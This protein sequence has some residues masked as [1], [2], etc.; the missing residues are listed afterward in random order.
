MSTIA[1]S[2]GSCRKVV[3]AICGIS[4]EADEGGKVTCR[5]C[6][7][8]QEIMSKR[9]AAH[10]SL[11]TQGVKMLKNSDAKFPPAKAGDN[12]R[13]RIP[14]VDR[15]RSDSRS[16]LAVVMNIKGTSY[17]LGTEHGVLKQL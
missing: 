9:S 2:C 17:K 10:G 12:V 11:Q 7:N 6:H 16:I 8:K 4:N 5:L 15:G 3:H 13:I 1:H 14:D